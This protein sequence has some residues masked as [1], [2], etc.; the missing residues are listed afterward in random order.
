MC[1]TLDVCQIVHLC[2]CKHIGSVGMQVL[3]HKT[4]DGFSFFFFFARSE[5]AGSLLTNWCSVRWL[6]A[7][8]GCFTVAPFSSG[9]WRA[10]CARA[11]VVFPNYFTFFLQTL[12]TE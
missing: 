5:L 4:G 10:M 8:G 7:G 6:A 12:H 1:K 9:W 2:C 3:R 11:F